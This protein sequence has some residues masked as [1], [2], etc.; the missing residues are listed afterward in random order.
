MSRGGGGLIWLFFQIQLTQVII[1]YFWVAE[2]ENH[3][4][5]SKQTAAMLEIMPYNVCFLQQ[6]I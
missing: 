2:S 6:S 4:D 5:A 1:T 3:S